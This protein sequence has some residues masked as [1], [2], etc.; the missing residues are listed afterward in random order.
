MDEL[1]R[2]YQ[3]KAARVGHYF[4]T[5][6]EATPTFQTPEPIGLLRVSL[7]VVDAMTIGSATI[8]PV[9]LGILAAITDRRADSLRAKHA[10]TARPARPALRLLGGGA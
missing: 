6:L 2:A 5:S 1:R 8:D 7:T 9:N 10:A 4:L 3:E